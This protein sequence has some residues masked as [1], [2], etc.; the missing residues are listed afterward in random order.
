MPDVTC[1]LYPKTQTMEGLLQ[2][3]DRISD[4]LTLGVVKELVRDAFSAGW[5][6]GREAEIMKKTAEPRR[7]R[8]VAAV[9][10]SVSAA[11]A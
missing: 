10:A 4:H 6:W 3:V 2:D 7:T 9:P 8:A 5:H 11:D 1:P